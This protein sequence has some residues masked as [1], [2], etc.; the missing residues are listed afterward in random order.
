MQETQLHIGCVLMAA[1]NSRRFGSNKLSVR[2]DGLTLAEYALNAIPS[3]AFSRVVV[4]TQYPEILELAKNRG[5]LCKVNREP[6]R[7]LSSTIRIGIEELLD[8]DAILFLVADQPM[9]RKETIENVVL[10]YR[11]NPDRIVV[12]GHEGR[13]GNPCIFPKEFNDELLAL[14]GD[15]GGVVVSKAHEDRILCFNVEDVRELIDVDT[16]HT[17]SELMRTP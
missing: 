11:E 1:G 17:L 6:E 7:G 8:M 3:E 16:E 10:L 15:M 2:L 13:R 9:L 14:T 5:F 12:A 4:V